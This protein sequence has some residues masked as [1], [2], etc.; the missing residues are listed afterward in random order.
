MGKLGTWGVGPDHLTVPEI[1]VFALRRG[2]DGDHE[3]Q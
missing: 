1:V 2:F 3:A